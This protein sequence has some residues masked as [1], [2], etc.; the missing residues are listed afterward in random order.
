MIVAHVQHDGTIAEL[1]GHYIERRIVDLH[2]IGAGNS[3]GQAA[4]YFSSH[5]QTVTLLVRGGSLEKSMSHYL[6]EQLR[7]KSNITCR[8]N[9]EIIAI[10]GDTHLTAL[11]LGS[12]I[13]EATEAGDF[14][15][16]VLGITVMC[17]MVTLFNRLLW[18]PLYAFGEQ[19][20]RLG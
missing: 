5:A 15:R 10:R 19:R 9:S 12:Y 4:I 8:L 1:N 7:G 18:R 17:V 16:V 11:G 2:L 3:A 6:I 20:L 14:A 13:A